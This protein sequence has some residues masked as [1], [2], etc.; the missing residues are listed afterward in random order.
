MDFYLTVELFIF[1]Y[2]KPGPLS[3]ILN[4]CHLL[5]TARFCFSEKCWKAVMAK[6][7]ASKNDTRSQHLNKHKKSQP[8]SQ[9]WRLF[10]NHLGCMDAEVFENDANHVSVPLTLT[11][12]LLLCRNT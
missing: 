1:K 3:Q 8:Q 2:I 7:D 12:L 11:L 9:G 10:K 4:R 6:A 5:L